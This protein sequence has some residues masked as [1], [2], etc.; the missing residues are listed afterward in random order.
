MGRDLRLE[1]ER[2]LTSLLPRP[3]PLITSPLRRSG[4]GGAGPEA[5][6]T[7]EGRARSGD[8]WWCTCVCVCAY[9]RWSVCGGIDVEVRWR[10]HVPAGGVLCFS[11]LF[12][13]QETRLACLRACCACG[14]IASTCGVLFYGDVGQLKCYVAQM[15]RVRSTLAICRRMTNFDG[16]SLGENIVSPN[17]CGVAD[18]YSNG[19]RLNLSRFAT[20]PTMTCITKSASIFFSI[21]LAGHANMHP[22][23]DDTY[24]IFCKGSLALWTPQMNAILIFA[25]IIND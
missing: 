5:R 8:I 18:V 21:Y 10:R 2:G 17:C 11:F 19:K 24:S 20:Y 6:P 16:S 3:K 25:C 7:I 12:A 22:S 23:S 1:K 15:T 9:S 13:A 14:E 4:K